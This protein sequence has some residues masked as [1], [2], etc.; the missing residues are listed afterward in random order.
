MPFLNFETCHSRV[1]M[2]HVID[3]GRPSAT[4][5]RRRSPYKTSL[6]RDLARVFLRGPLFRRRI[7][8]EDSSVSSYTTSYFTDTESASDSTSSGSRRRSARKTRDVSDDAT[9]IRA[10]LPHDKP[11]HIRRTL[12]QFYYYML[13]DTTIRDNDQVVDRWARQKLG[14]N[15]PR[16]LMVDQL[17]LWII[18]DGKI[19]ALGFPFRG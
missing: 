10:Y 15:N 19:Y 3:E 12:D 1:N 16:I 18:N 17:W 4:T 9:L 2:S 6:R 7:V 13:E 5:R 8:E 14:K 11:L